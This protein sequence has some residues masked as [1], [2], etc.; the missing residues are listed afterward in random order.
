MAGTKAFFFVNYEELRQPRSTRRNRQI[1][2]PQAEQGIFRYSASGG[3]QTVNL[4][5]LAARSGQLAIAGSDHLAVAGRH[6]RPRRAPKA[7]SAISPTRSTRSTRSVV[8][9]ETK[10]RYPT[11]RLDYNLNDQHRLTYSMNF[12]YSPAVRKPGYDEQPRAATSLG[13]RSMASQWSTRRAA[14]GWLRSILG[15]TL[16]NE[17]RIGYGGAP[18][19]LLAE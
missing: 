5:E 18:V 17:V 11:V 14:S 13:S 16:V 4:F 10:N 3:V 12:Q 2:H 15:P 6:P 7:T 19:D 9:T 1:L 8:P